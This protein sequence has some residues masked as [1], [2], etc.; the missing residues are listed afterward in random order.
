MA[1]NRG[2]EWIESQKC[3]EL[4]GLFSEF[5]GFGFPRVYCVDVIQLSIVCGYPSFPIRL[6]LKQAS[7]FFDIDGAFCA[8]PDIRKW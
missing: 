5:C 6:N 2:F 7:S 8:I 3:N 1:T 4:K